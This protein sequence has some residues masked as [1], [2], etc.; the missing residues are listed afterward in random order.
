MRQEL[1]LPPY[2][3]RAQLVAAAI[4]DSYAY[5]IG[6][7]RSPYDDFRR[8]VGVPSRRCIQRHRGAYRP[9]LGYSLAVAVW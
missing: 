5:G 6:A 3:P 9:L 8:Y 2:G 1:I 7:R 4:Y